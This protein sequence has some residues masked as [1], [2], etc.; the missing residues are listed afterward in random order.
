VAI[1][2]APSILNADF[3]N[4][5]REIAR[6]SDAAQWLHV[7]VMDGHFVP[8]LTIGLPVVESLA[9]VSPIPLDAHLM[10]ED[11]TRWAPL[12]IEAGATS[13][14]FHIEAT[15]D[16]R[17]TIDAIRGAGGRVGCAFKPGTPLDADIVSL[18]DMVVIMTV[19]PGF[20]GQSFMVDMMAKVSQARTL[21]T[22]L[23]RE[24]WIQVDGGISDQTIE[25]AARAGAD[26][27]VA[28]SAVYRS[29]DPQAMVRSL[30]NLAT[31]S[32]SSEHP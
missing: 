22:G 7:D 13:A 16:A 10:I 11:P 2:I 9:R 4:L 29:D 12:Y 18:V 14:T 23:D 3:A 20:G 30:R 19:E 21:I 31:E 24:V 17:S 32:H 27:F 6:I 8:N 26:V 5:E 1:Q 28:G 25:M 15:T